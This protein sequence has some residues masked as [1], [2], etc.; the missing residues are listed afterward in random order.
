MRKIVTF[1]AALLGMYALATS[2]QTPEVDAASQTSSSQIPA[3]PNSAPLLDSINLLPYDPVYFI[4]GKRGTDTAKFQIS[5]KHQLF[6]SEG[7]FSRNLR[8]PTGVYLGY[9]QTTVWDL[10]ELSSPFKDTSYR[11]RI[12]YLKEGSR[13]KRHRL[14]GD[15]E[16]GFSHESNGKA[17]PESR[18]VNQLYAKPTLSYYLNATRR[19]YVTPQ[20]NWYLQ[21]TDNPD[22]AKYRGHVDLVLG[23]GSGNRDQ[24]D[25]GVWTLLRRSDDNER[26]SVE[27]NVAAPWRRLTGNRIN[28]WFLFQYFNG[29]GE[30]L[31]DYNVRHTAQFRMGIGLLIQ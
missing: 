6:R 13:S 5:F 28:G 19:I 18:G 8:A 16:G 22:L 29:Y 21:R 31:I 27:V 4:A 26:G 2:A 7:W 12:F 20:V 10:D 1:V 3:S 23:Y 17:D 11:P 30:S 9:T 24:N 15:L 14:A 25:W